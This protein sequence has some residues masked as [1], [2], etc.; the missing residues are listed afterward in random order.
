[1]HKRNTTSSG[2]T[3]VELLIVIVV[4][5]VLAAISVVAYTGI[6]HRATASAVQNDLSQAQKKLM[7]FHV[8]NGRY[9]ASAAELS[10]AEIS[11][12]KSA[13]GTGNN[14]YYCLNT[15]SG[16]FAIGA[17]IAGNTE[18]YYVA[19]SGGVRQAPSQVTW[20]STC[21][22]AGLT[23]TSDPGAVIS[24]G[25]LSSTGWQSWVR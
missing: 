2:F 1:M 14:F 20:D 4:I 5:A 16:Q 3:I 13:Y 12:T 15:N 11:A 8:D 18:S 23:G 10:T 6:Q 21:Q 9:P 19:S 7:L 24:A 25:Y 17:R 22:E